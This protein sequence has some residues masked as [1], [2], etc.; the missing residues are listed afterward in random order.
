MR[1]SRV[2]VAGSLAYDRIMDFQGYFRDHF[3]PEK[4]HDISVSFLVSS[5][6]EQFGGTAGNIAYSLALLG[7]EPAIIATAGTDFD[8][9]AAHCQACGIPVDTIERASD[10]PTASAYIMADKTNSQIAAFA[11]GA[12][13]RAYERSLD[14]T[15]A[16]LAI[17]AP[18]CDEDMQRVPEEAKKAGV[19]YFFD[20]GQRLTS[21]PT[22]LLRAGIEGAAALFVNDYELALTLERTGWSEE[23][24]RTKVGLLV[25]T[26][27]AEGSRI[28]T[29]EGEERVT[30]VAATLADPTGAGDAYRA[31]FI[32]GYLAKLPAAQCAK[33]GSLIAAYAVEQ[34]GTQAHTPRP[35]EMAARFTDA[36]GSPWP[37]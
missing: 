5:V 3:L 33:L 24:L 29:P 12:G 9:Y 32:A 36:Y 1:M 4:L 37:L 18:T 19:P 28:V 35:E 31:G 10:L 6:T 15:D 17:V 14:F 7:Q 25:V 22:E 21:L 13:A 2:L 11:P 26:L 30:A 16:A 20:P 34:V 27:G 8:R 23:E